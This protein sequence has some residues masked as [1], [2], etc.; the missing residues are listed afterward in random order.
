MNNAFGVAAFIFGA[1][2]GSV[3]T[4]YVVKDKY[5]KLAQEEIDSVKEVFSKKK[6]SEDDEASEN[7]PDESNDKKAEFTKD[8]PDIFEYTKKRY[9]DPAYET[10]DYTSHS[11]KEDDTWDVPPEDEPEDDDEP[12]GEPEVETKEWKWNPPYVISPEEAGEGDYDVTELTYYSDQ[13]LADELDD[14]V[15]DPE[16]WVTFE[17]LGHFG[18]YEDDSVYVRNERLHCD[19]AILRDSRRWSDV[20]KLKKTQ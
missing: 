10:V 4:W 19:F 9:G 3:A 8:K 16:S 14:I 17:A 5:E 13:I 1:A 12:E 7:E 20:I 11:V 15:E 18:E 6:T 2:V